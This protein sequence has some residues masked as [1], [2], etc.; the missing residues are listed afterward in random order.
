MKQIPNIITLLNLFFGCLAVL[1]ALQTDSIIIKLDEDYNTSFNIPEKLVWA[2]ICIGIAACIDFLD[3]FVAR[4]LKASSSL[5]KQLDSLS[6]VVS[7]G[8]APSMIIYQLLRISFARQENGLEISII[9]L[10]PA[11]IIACSAAYRLA[12]F[13]ID[14]SQQYNFKGVP[15]P[16]IGLLIASFPLILF[17]NSMPQIANFFANKWFLYGVI[18]S[19]S[20]LMLTNIP[21][22]GLKFMSYKFKDN[23]PKVILASIAVISA[24]FL[25]WLAVPV[26]FISYILIS[27]FT[28]KSIA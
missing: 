3:G 22:I 2:A 4:W 26:I 12:K 15:T 6:D 11:F 24:I 23:I 1:F 13:N 14:E 19:L 17:Y 5:G 9:L 20:W 7:F 28:K 27:L 10:V 18:I 21:M 16:A 25:H 8:V